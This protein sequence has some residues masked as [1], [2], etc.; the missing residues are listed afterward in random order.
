MYKNY[1]LS[2]EDAQ[3]LRYQMMCTRRHESKKSLLEPI[4]LLDS[5]E[6][7]KI[8]MRERCDDYWDIG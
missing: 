8:H 7:L 5:E 6:M 3:S 4:V 1:D 2:D